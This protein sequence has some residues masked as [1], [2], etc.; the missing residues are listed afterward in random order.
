[1][2]EERTQVLRRIRSILRET[3]QVFF[4]QIGKKHPDTIILANQSELQQAAGSRQRGTNTGLARSIFPEA[5]DLLGHG[6]DHV[7][8]ESPDGESCADCRH[9]REYHHRDGFCW[10]DV[11]GSLCACATYTV[12]EESTQPSCR[13]LLKLWAI[14][15]GDVRILILKGEC[16]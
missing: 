6:S 14:V 11:D 3:E 7:V 12:N 5:C 13:T 1:M 10:A 15:K 16:C 8:A 4:Q 9:L 2:R